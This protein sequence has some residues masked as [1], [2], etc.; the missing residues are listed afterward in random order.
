MLTIGVPSFRLEKTVIDA[1]IDVLRT[2]GVEFRC[3]IEVGR[4]VTIQELREQGYEAF[5]V[6][7]GAQGGRQV[8]VPGEDAVG[9]ETGVD[10]LRRLNLDEENMKVSG[11]SVIIGGGNVAIDVA[12]SVLRAG[13]SEVS[14]Y[15]LES[16]AEMPASAEEV[17]ETV[18]E[19]IVIHNGWGPKEILKDEEGRVKGIIMRRCLSVFDE[20]R[21]FRPQY[22]ENDTCQIDCEQVFLS[23]GQAILWGE[24][25]N[26]TAV[27]TNPNKTVKADAVTFQTAEP[28]IFVGG[29]AYTGPRF[30]ID[31]IA[32]GKEAAESIHRFVHK[33][34]SLTLGRDLRHFIELDK[35][36]VKLESFDTAKRQIPGRKAGPAT[37]TFRDLRATLTAE[38]VQIEAARCLG[39]GA[40]IVD[41]NRCIGCGLC[42]TKCEFDA[43]HL[44]RDI[45][46]A[47]RMRTSEDKLK[48]ILP[49]A[50]KRAVKILL[51]RKK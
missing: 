10:F 4:D 19:E 1:E 3:G 22:D 8:G 26:G 14:M 5:Y 20:E 37:R 38:Q 35:E 12:R 34:H 13:S 43:I 45:P 40:S 42:T 39:C 15:C 36:D 11:R 2:M 24:L 6:A 21:R 7:I 49:Y 51:K 17:A 46:E 41:E 31:A 28:D 27:E 25:L 30:A 33:G 47:S 50:A 16:V 44:S 9:V 23:V 32:Q 29:D 18:E 48:G